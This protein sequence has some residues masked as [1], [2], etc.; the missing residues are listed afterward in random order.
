METRARWDLARRR[1]ASPGS[2]AALLSCCSQ[3]SEAELSEGHGV[4]PFMSASLTS[5][6]L[7]SSQVPRAPAA[8][9]SK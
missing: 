7:I 6:N 4:T 9:G 8:F 5:E 3:G 2:A 1:A